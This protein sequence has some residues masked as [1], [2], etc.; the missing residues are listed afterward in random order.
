M[1]SFLLALA[2]FAAPTV[3]AVPG[4]TL[5]KA[6]SKLGFAGTVAGQTF[7]GEFARWDA[8]IRFDPKMLG[9]S[10]VLITVE[11]VSAFTGD[12]TRDEALPTADWFSVETFPRATFEASR[13]IDLGGGRYQAIGTLTIRDIRQP[14]TLPFEL[15][16]QGDEAHVVGVVTLDRHVFGVGRGQFSTADMVALPVEVRF[17][18]IAKP[19]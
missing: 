1:R 9:A 18:L 3:A 8:R 17:D 19:S 4:W 7:K 2:L 15:R 6:H 10:S 16:R 5:D 14:L 13:F 11:T 12:K